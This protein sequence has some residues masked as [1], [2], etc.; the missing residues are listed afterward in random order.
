[1]VT[2]GNAAI[3]RLEAVITAEPEPSLSSHWAERHSD[4]VANQ[5]VVTGARG[6][7]NFT[8]RTLRHRVAHRMA[9]VPMRAQMAH[10]RS[11]PG[12][13][14]SGR[15]V[16][17]KQGRTL[18]LDLLRQV[19][20]LS[21][22][23]EFGV[24]RS[25]AST[26]LVIGDGFGAFSS[27]VLVHWPKSRV[28]VVNLDKTLLVDLIFLRMVLGPQ[29][30]AGTRLVESASELDAALSDDRV[31]LIGLR[32]RDAV[33]A[34]AVPAAWAVNV[35]SMQ[36]MLSEDIDVYFHV[37]RDI[38]SVRSLKFY[39][40][41]R[42]EKSHPDGTIIRFSDY[43]WLTEDVFLLDELCPWHQKYYSFR[44]P[45]YRRYDGPIRH[46]VVQI[47]PRAGG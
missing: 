46:A 28:V 26:V 36:E 15:I 27:M 39:C 13:L 24:R 45:S 5:G 12:A 23:E 30:D 20:T 41:N 3:A 8:P 1:M 10:Y 42:V 47:S 17:K 38:A 7:G 44:P 29:F 14:R 21:I 11:F 6:F 4:F 34:S 18:D 32:A 35:A 16:A 40:C 19:G 31:R 25:G 37:L 9:Q 33:L 43:P 2:R 22:I